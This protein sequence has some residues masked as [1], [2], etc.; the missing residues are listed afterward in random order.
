VNLA[1]GILSGSSCRINTGRRQK[2]ETVK[3]EKI[4]TFVKKDTNLG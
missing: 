3:L 2:E 1:E 4:E